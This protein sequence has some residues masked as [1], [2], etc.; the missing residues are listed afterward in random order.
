MRYLK[1]IFDKELKLKI[2]S[3]ENKNNIPNK[4]SALI[5]VIYTKCLKVERSYYK[6]Q[7]EYRFQSYLNRVCDYFY[8]LKD[9]V[10]KEM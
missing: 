5:E 7:K 8:L 4:L 1:R 10:N 9:Y 3:K 2:N 6:L